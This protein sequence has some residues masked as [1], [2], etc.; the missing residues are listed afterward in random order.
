MKCKNCGIECDKN[1]C[2]NCG[3]KICDED[4]KYIVNSK[5]NL[6]Y[7]ICEDIIS[8][9]ELSLIFLILFFDKIKEYD[10]GIIIFFCCMVSII[11][12]KTIIKMINYRS[13]CYRFYDDKMEYIDCK[14]N[15]E[16]KSIQ[17]QNIKQIIFKQNLLEKIFKIGTIKF[18][19]NGFG[20]DSM[21]IAKYIINPHNEYQKIKN[22]IQK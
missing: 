18:I 8:F 1:Y 12:G 11:F 5:F 20:N 2:A 16:E 21:V 17:Y 3:Q 10:I 13:V 9:I 15:K 6:A 7:S 22:I 4:I 14:F 19:T